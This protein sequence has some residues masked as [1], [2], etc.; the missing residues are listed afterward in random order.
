MFT[1]SPNQKRIGLSIARDAKKISVTT[2]TMVNLESLLGLLEL[3][4]LDKN[5][6]LVILCVI[7]DV[8]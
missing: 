6:L 4:A 8:S 3:P 1:L 7:V 2:V 5:Y